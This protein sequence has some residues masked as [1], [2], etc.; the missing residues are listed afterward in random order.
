MIRWA[1]HENRAQHW[2]RFSSSARELIQFV[3][4]KCTSR[5][6]CS[7]QLCLMVARL[8]VTASFL[9]SFLRTFSWKISWLSGSWENSS[10]FAKLFCSL[11]LSAQAAH[12]LLISFW[13]LISSEH[14]ECVLSSR[15]SFCFVLSPHAD[16]DDVLFDVRRVWCF[17]LACVNPGK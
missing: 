3:Q 8:D 17:S 1:W 6:C 2:A 7:G 16:H 11:Y 5:Y 10:L 13:K 12:K 15:V 14:P 9:R 4:G